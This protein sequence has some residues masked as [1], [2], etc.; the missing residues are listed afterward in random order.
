M[1]MNWK[2]T[3]QFVITFLA[4]FLEKHVLR[5]LAS[6]L[7]T[8][9]LL[10][11]H[12]SAHRSG[13]STETV[14]LRILNDLFTSLDGNK[15]SILLLLDLSAASNRPRNSSLS[16]QT[17]LWHS[18]NSPELVSVLPFWQV[19]IILCHHRRPEINR[20]MKRGFA[21]C[22]GDFGVPQDSVFGPVLFILY[23]AP[24]ACLI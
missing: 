14:L 21:C 16:P 23:T 3:D 6:H 18:W 22:A 24:L 9:S 20:N 7:S 19:A 4:K 1:Q 17:W 11:F 15:I 2:S 12:Q 8:H 13:H 10:S 5:Q